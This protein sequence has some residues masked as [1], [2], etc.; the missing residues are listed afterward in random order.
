MT[1]KRFLTTAAVL[2]ISLGCFAQGPER[3]GEGPRIPGEDGMKRLESE[4]IAFF[5]AE[6]DLSPE[7][8]QVFW[9]VYNQYSKESREAHGETMKA[10]WALKDRKGEAT[11]AQ[12]KERIETYIKAQQKEQN[13]LPGYNDKF[14]K[15]LPAKKVGKLYLAEEKFRMQMLQRLGDHKPMPAMGH[16]DRVPGD[17]GPM[18]DKG[19]NQKRPGQKR[20]LPGQEQNKA[21]EPELN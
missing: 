8:A 5:T 3:N 14:L 7:E 17:K 13:L 16:G 4:K 21:K 19:Q 1:S 12:M 10:L 6:L 20:N 2:F 18:M 15:V 9:P 11:D